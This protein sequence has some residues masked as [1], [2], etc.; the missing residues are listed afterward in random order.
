M[1]DKGAEALQ[2]SKDGLFSKWCWNT[3]ISTGKKVNLDKPYTLYKN[4]LKVNHRPKCKVQNYK[5][6]RR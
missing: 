1:F 5:P 4:Y 6:P 3:W 2:W